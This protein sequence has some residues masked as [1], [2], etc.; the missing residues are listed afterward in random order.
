MNNSDEWRA[1]V[2]FQLQIMKALGWY[3]TINKRAHKKDAASQM[4]VHQSLISQAT[5]APSKAD[6][7]DESNYKENNIRLISF[8]RALKIC[9]FL[10]VTIEDVLYYYQ[11]RNSL[12]NMTEI[13][14]LQNLTNKFTN[15][16]SCQEGSIQMTKDIESLFKVDNNLS[17]TSNLISDVRNPEFSQWFGKYYCYFSST[18]STEAGKRRNETFDKSSDN[19]EMKELLDCS[20]SDYIFC[21][22]LDIHDESK[23]KDGLCHVDFKFLSNPKKRRIK[24]YSGIL[25]LSAQTK[26]V[27]C[28]LI[29]NDQG[30]KT[31]SIFEKQDLGPEFSHV[32]CCIAMVLTYSSKCHRRR[33]CCER[34]IIS[35]KMIKENT[36]EYDTMKAY[37]LMNDNKIRITKRKYGELIKEIEQSTDQ[38]LQSIKQ[39]FP[40][41]QSLK[42]NTVKIEECAFIPE[43]E[44]YNLHLLTDIQKQKFEVLLRLYSIA[45]WYCKTKATKTDML[46]E[47]LNSPRK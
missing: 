3:F 12:V 24:R 31:Y 32:Q 19:E 10:D 6:K 18:S 36:R 34:M 4:N 29:S 39:Y 14:K 30:E 15:F 26:A 9:D 45:P 41:L 27:F 20:T 21:G 43:S 33:P 28:E 16:E 35:R 8:S 13:D 11:H 46:F 5:I 47:L 38:D 44:I 7:I 22:I 40:N 1:Q 42:G 17:R 2:K 23:S 25:T 37:L